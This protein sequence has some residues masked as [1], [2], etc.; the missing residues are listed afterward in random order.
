MGQRTVDKETRAKARKISSRLRELIEVYKL[1]RFWTFTFF[2]DIPDHVRMEKWHRFMMALRKSHPKLQYF[3]IKEPHPK[4]GRTHFHVLFGEYV[5][6]HL[7]QRLWEGAGCGKVVQVLKLDRCGIERYIT[8]YM[9]KAIGERRGSGTAYSS[10]RLFC[11]HLGC[12]P[13]WCLKL[14]SLGRTDIVPFLLD[15]MDFSRYYEC[16][17]RAKRL[18]MYQ[19]HGIALALEEV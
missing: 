11:L 7:V 18:L 8:K 13:K 5:D 15:K 17:G 16:A 2:A 10:S 4:S 9:T 1:S 14:F 6:W 3:L 19:V 12:F